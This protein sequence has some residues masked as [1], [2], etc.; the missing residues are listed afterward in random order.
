[1][2]FSL[3]KSVPIPSY[4]LPRRKRRRRPCSGTG[5]EDGGNT[6]LFSTTAGADPG[7]LKGGGGGGGGQQRKV[8]IKWERG[9]V[10]REGEEYAPSLREART[11][12]VAVRSKCN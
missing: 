1:M 4:A 3:F 5:Y 2:K 12:L 7:I 8:I 9:V 11:L 10:H 6:L